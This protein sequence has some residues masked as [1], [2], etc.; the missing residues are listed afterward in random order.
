MHREIHKSHRRN[1]GD[2]C[3][4]TKQIA[5]PSFGT[6]E[7]K[8][9]GKLNTIVWECTGTGFLGHNSGEIGGD[10]ATCLRLPVRV[11]DSALVASHVLVI[12]LPGLRVNRLTHT[13]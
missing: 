1:D 12:P 5:T 11:Y 10:V 6:H 8:L 13:A 7:R 2:T 9:R 3:F 4:R